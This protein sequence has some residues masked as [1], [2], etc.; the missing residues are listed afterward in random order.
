[1][2]LINPA[3]S[4]RKSSVSV[5]A[6]DW[7]SGAQ[8]SRASRGNGWIGTFAPLGL[9]DFECYQYLSVPQPLYSTKGPDDGEF[10]GLEGKA[11]QWQVQQRGRSA[12]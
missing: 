2:Q 11:G 9:M 5:E 3:P 6:L 10:Q 7:E 12:G 4:S 1:M 8:C